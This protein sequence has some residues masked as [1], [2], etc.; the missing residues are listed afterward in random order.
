YGEFRAANLVRSDGDPAFQSRVEDSLNPP[1]LTRCLLQQED[2]SRPGSRRPSKNR[3]CPSHDRPSP[4]LQPPT[5]LKLLPRR[6]PVW[7]STIRETRR[8]DRGS[9]TYSTAHPASSIRELHGAVASRRNDSR[10]R[11]ACHFRFLMGHRV[12]STRIRLRAI[13]VL[14]LSERSIHCVWR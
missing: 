8:H 6:L 1:N 3:S 10:R 14:L 4:N 5:H 12:G 13:A 11:Q 9:R 2:Y 7:C